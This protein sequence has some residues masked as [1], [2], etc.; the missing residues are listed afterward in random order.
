MINY[1]FGLVNRAEF[2][3][4]MEEV[5]VEEI[6]PQPVISEPNPE[7]KLEPKTEVKEKVI[8]KVKKSKKKRGGR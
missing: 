4:V 1:I 8:R 2:E 3:A 5:K 6:K 7:P